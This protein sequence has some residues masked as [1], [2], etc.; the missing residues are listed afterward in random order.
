VLPEGAV[1][2]AAFPKYNLGLEMKKKTAGFLLSIGF[3]GLPAMALADGP[4][5]SDILVNSG[6]TA[7]GYLDGSYEAT[8]NKT[9]GGTA[10]EVPL[11]EFDTNANSFLFNQAGLTLSYLPTS[12]FG[13]LVNVIAG[14]DA[15]II[16][17]TYGDSS[18]T[19]FSLTQ[20]YV[21]WATGNFTVIGGRFVT[22][23]GAE[24]IDDTKNA[25]ISRSLLFTNLEPLVHTGV[26]ASYKFSDLVTGYL[27]VNNTAGTPAGS[28]ADK[29][30][31]IETG[32]AFTFSKTLSLA[33]ADYYG[34]D[35]NDGSQVKDNYLDAVATFQA[36]DALALVLNGDYVRF[37]G[38]GTNENIEG[39]AAYASYQLLPN[40]KGSVRAEYVRFSEFGS[41]TDVLEGTITADYSPATNF[42]VL[43]EFRTDYSATGSNAGL[44]PN[45]S[46]DEGEDGTVDLSRKSQPEVLIKAI[47][48]FGTPVPTT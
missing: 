4:G 7:A 19:P 30:K 3:A 44:F 28:D 11:H 24:V 14:E 33:L 15:K 46:V 35:G 18:S 36:T 40:L 22:L 9:N 26:R 47:W 32:A 29:H 37:I 43:G 1:Q 31:T 8:F 21:Q 17:G 38:N 20:A 48:K 42:D 45:G 6:I 39:L 5:L 10:G 12:G 13:G 41:N 34:V 25:N 27:G 16:N 2:K 23:A